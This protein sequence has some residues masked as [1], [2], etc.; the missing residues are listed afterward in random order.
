VY[1]VRA[2]PLL[3]NAFEWGSRLLSGGIGTGGEPMRGMVATEPLRRFLNG[4]LERAPD[5]SLPG[6]GRNLDRG[7]LKAVALSATSYSTGQSLT[8]I[9]GRNVE[10]WQRPQRRTE[11]T[12]LTVE[13]VLASSA[14]PMLFPA[15]K[16]DGQWYG[17][18]GVRLTAPLSP[19]LHLGA[20][21]IITISTKYQRTRAEADQPLTVGYPPPAQV[22][23]VLYNAVFL[24][25]ID[26]DILRLQT[27]NQL[28][29]QMKHDQREKMRIV[30]I[31]VLRPSC[32]LGKLASEFE[33]RLPGL[34][35]YLTRG[36][37]TRRTASPDFISLILFQKDYLKRLIDI[38]EEDAAM[39]GDQIEEF[40]A[41]P[42]ADTV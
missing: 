10:L 35:R 7:T 17:D 31:L 33:P 14:L 37:G 40:L 38:G 2:A 20:S 12:K 4:V 18:G 16:V 32:D 29:R 23:G 1:D 41:R 5:G 6:I 27:V 15:V 30:D 28:L 21:R 22:L 3:R 9:E 36:L 34:F 8:W 13:H 24:D 42:L 11:N 26:E 39:Q 25:L 19:S